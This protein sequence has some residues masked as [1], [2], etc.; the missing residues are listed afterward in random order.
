[1][2]F[3]LY[4]KFKKPKHYKSIGVTGSQEKWV[5]SL[6]HVARYAKLEN[7]RLTVKFDEI[8][9]ISF[10]QKIPGTLAT[11]GFHNF[12]LDVLVT[13]CSGLTEVIENLLWPQ[14][15]LTGKDLN[16]SKNFTRIPSS[17]YLWC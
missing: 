14:P 4:Y 16:L 2:F 8:S 13:F 11:A 6:K 15:T 3:F 7:G 9:V 12:A 1:M 5:E 10:G 17:G